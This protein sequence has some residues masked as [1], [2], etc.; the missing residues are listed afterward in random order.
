[1][2][3]FVNTVDVLGGDDAMTDALIQRTLTELWDNRITRLRSR[4]LAGCTTLTEVNVPNVTYINQYAFYGCTA[5]TMLDTNS[6]TFIGSMAFYYCDAL[7]A[8]ILRGDTV[9]SLES[10]L[11]LS[12]SSIEKG[13]GYIYIKRAL[14][15]S[16]KAATNWSTFSAQIR[17]LEDYTVDGT[18]TGELDETKI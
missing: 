15:D 11:A 8:L 18:T 16:Y 6:V 10:T 17:A 5:L 1:M 14:V 9:C 12:Y 7:T 2:S 4:A 3:D 13:T